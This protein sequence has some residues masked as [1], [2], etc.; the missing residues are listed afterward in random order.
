MRQRQGLWKCLG[1]SPPP[2]P[3]PERLLRS[4]LQPW[5]FPQGSVCVSSLLGLQDL[6]YWARASLLPVPALPATPRWSSGS[7]PPC[8]LP[9][10]TQWKLVATSLP[11]PPTLAFRWPAHWLLE[12]DPHRSRPLLRVNS[13]LFMGQFTCRT[14]PGGEGLTCV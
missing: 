12:P 7:P 4:Q 11:Y 13:H 1:L 14:N 2:T 5:G 10:V 3:T 6:I 9:A 8:S